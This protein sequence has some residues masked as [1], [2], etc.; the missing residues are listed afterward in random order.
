MLF[1]GASV[2][3]GSKLGVLPN[4]NAGRWNDEAWL[5]LNYTSMLSPEVVQVPGKSVLQKGY[6]QFQWWPL[7][8]EV[9]EAS[10]VFAVQPAK[11]EIR[12]RMAHSQGLG[13][14]PQPLVL[15]EDSFAP[16]NVLGSLAVYHNKAHNQYQVG[17]LCHIYR[18][19]CI[20]AKGQRVWCDPLV[21]DGEDVVIGLPVDWLKQAVYPV[22]AMGAGDTFGYTTGGGTS[23]S[24]TSSSV[25]NAGINS[26]MFLTATTGDT[27]SG[28][29]VYASSA[30]GAGCDMT[31][32]SG[33]TSGSL[34]NGSPRGF[35]GSTASIASGGVLD[36]YSVTGLSQALTNAL[37]YTVAIGNRTGTG[38][39][40]YDTEVGA[41]QSLET[42][43]TF[44]ATWTE[45]ST[46]NRK[47]SRYATYSNI[48]AGNPWYY[49]AGA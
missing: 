33:A 23:A 40:R 28:Y 46:N 7:N 3:A 49:Y 4:I 30:A 34:P 16:D 47:Y 31:V 26:G 41:Q 36:W 43:T 17:K 19:E 8:E 11:T 37:V 35:A 38:G 27:I 21:V 29:S 20:D 42:A 2:I 1:N 45:A 15:D 22:I 18:W 24:Q 48:S 5:N 10:V 6:E 32:Y 13:F 12:L 9:L 25:C 14:Y 39:Y 44:Q